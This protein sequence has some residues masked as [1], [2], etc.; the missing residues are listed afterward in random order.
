MFFALAEGISKKVESSKSNVDM[1][2]LFLGLM[3][4]LL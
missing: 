1:K 3:L 2:K 4:S